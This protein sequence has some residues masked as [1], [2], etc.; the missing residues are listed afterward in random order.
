MINIALCTDS[1]YMMAC[2]PCLVSIFEH[3]PANS[4][5][6]YVITK[7]LSESDVTGMQKLAKEY[8]QQLTVVY[9]H[10]GDL[11]HL[12]VCER[13]RESIYYRLLLPELLPQLDKVL[14]LDCDILVNDSLDGLWNTDITEYACAVVEDQEG[15]DI[16]LHNRI[17]VYTTY[18]NSGVLLMNLVY[19][20]KHSLAEKVVNYIYENP[21]RCFFP[22]QD[23]M[24]VVLQNQVKFLPYGYN[25]QDLWFLTDRQWIRLHGSKF[26]E[27]D[28]WISHPIV[29]HFAGENKPWRKKCVHPYRQYYLD[30]LA[31]TPWTLARYKKPK[32]TN[33]AHKYLRRFNRV[34]IALILETIVFVIYVMLTH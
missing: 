15:D 12:K 24:N 33:K 16:T 34:L 10:P 19:W 13:F 29:I 3:H 31:K 6:V 32:D 27:V 8:N 26:E 14:Y 18:F 2:G 11:T 25:F 23:A 28:K 21:E 7:E 22:D 4:C 20:R 30:C 9:I 17:G 1:Y 5:H